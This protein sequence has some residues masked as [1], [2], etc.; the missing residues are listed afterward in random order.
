MKLGAYDYLPRPFEPEKLT[1]T[2]K[3]A[4]ETVSLRPEVRD[5]RRRQAGQSDLDYVVGQSAAIQ[6]VIALAAKVARSKATGILI[7]GDSGTGKNLLARLVH[8]ESARVQR[9]FMEI[10]CTSLAETL[11][12][13]ELFG[14][15]R[16]AFTDAKTMKKGLLEL[17]DGGTLL[18]DEIGGISPHLQ[19]KLLG[20]IEEKRFKR[21]GGTKDI[22]ID[23]RIVASTNRDLD[24]LVREGRFR[25]DLYFRLNVVRITIPP[26]RERIEDILPLARFFV[27][28]FNREFKREV[29]GISPEAATLLTRYEWPGNVR[30]LRN[31]IERAMILEGGEYLLPHDLP[32]E[33]AGVAPTRRASCQVLLPEGG[34]VLGDIERSL[35]CQALERTGGNQVQAASLLGIS[36]HTLRYRMQKYGLA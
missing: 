14:H 13:S 29:L 18:L 31:V 17:C 20:F 26:L 33:I 11:G 25:E 21:V 28:H 27:D 2:V 4:L 1:I 7:Q 6:Q 10:K 24:S 3:N 22:A 35:I 9:P 30:E 5:F 16:G 36:R 19:T 34:V 15:E 12:E 23:V 8:F 32:Q